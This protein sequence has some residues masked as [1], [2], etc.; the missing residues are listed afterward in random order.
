MSKRTD[1]IRNLFAQSPPAMLSAD[2]SPPEPR[3]VPAGA[4][5]S[6]KESFSE[7]EREN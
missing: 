2:N 4:V 7:I 5:R 3:R 6:M 1:T